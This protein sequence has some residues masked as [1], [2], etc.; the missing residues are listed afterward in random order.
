MLPQECL[1]TGTNRARTL[2]LATSR[3]SQHSPSAATSGLV[4]GPGSIR[5]RPRARPLEYTLGLSCCPWKG[6]PLTQIGFDSLPAEMHSGS[7]VATRSAN[8]VGDLL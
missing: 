5:A 8:V 4:Q 3:S 7:H 6:N 2:H 1:R